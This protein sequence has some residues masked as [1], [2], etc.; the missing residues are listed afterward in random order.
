VEMDFSQIL[1]AIIAKLVL[2][3]VF[4]AQVNCFHSAQF[5]E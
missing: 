4:N 1:Q 5:V 3:D 2:V